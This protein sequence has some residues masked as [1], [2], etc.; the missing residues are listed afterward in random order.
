VVALPDVA[1]ERRRATARDRGDDAALL[2][3]QA[4]ELLAVGPEDV[5]QLRVALVGYP[6]RHRSLIRQLDLLGVGQEVVERALRVPDEALGHV[7][8]DLG[9]P[10][11]PVAEEALESPEC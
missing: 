11:A 10:Q 1:P 5:R 4:T 6:G 7:G 8:V 3:A 9:R 2:R